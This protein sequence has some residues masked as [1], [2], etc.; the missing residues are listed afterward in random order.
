[1]CLY[2]MK[3]QGWL[4]CSVRR[5]LFRAR[6]GGIRRRGHVHGRDLEIL[7]FG[8]CANGN[9]VRC[10]SC[11]VHL[12]CSASACTGLR[13]VGLS[14]QP[15]QDEWKNVH[16]DKRRLAW[17]HPHLTTQH[18]TYC[19][20]KSSVSPSPW[21]INIPPS[22]HSTN[23]W[24]LLQVGPPWWA[25]HS[26]GARIPP[27]VVGRCLLKSYDANA[28]CNRRQPRGGSRSK[29][30]FLSPGHEPSLCR[31]SSAGRGRP[32][33]PQLGREQPQHPATPHPSLPSRHDIHPVGARP[34]RPLYART[35]CLS[36]ATPS[37][38]A[39]VAHFPSSALLPH[40]RAA[41]TSS[42]TCES[43]AA[44]IPTPLPSTW[45]RRD[46]HRRRRRQLG[47]HP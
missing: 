12:E 30:H 35:V 31:G 1:M 10:A 47:G 19:N 11:A 13:L 28:N 32:S 16:S 39:L 25:L 38:H 41:G 34:A 33:S 46:G 45:A 18:G 27:C 4:V 42:T 14:C 37:K 3:V 26:S 2:V 24:P 6:M 7:G 17:T 43:S 21:F 44:S 23:G 20:Q 8:R 36:R 9:F 29:Q 5:G 15:K 22:L 40:P